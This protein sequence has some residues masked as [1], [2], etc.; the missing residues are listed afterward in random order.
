VEWIIPLL[1]RKHV[2]ENGGAVSSIDSY[3]S[4]QNPFI[5]LIQDD[6]SKHF[7]AAPHTYRHEP[8]SQ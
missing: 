3:M 4:R 6:A 8:W 1:K 2:T 7:N 5:S